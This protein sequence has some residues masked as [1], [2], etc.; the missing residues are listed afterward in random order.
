MNNSFYIELFK[1]TDKLSQDEME[2]LIDSKLFNKILITDIHP[3]FRAYTIAHEGI[4]KGSNEF[5]REIVLKYVKSIIRKIYQTLQTDIPAY[6]RHYT[7]AD[8]YTREEIGTIV[9]KTIIDNDGILETI[10]IIYIKPGWRDK[11][12]DVASL[13]GIIE[14]VDDTVVNVKE[15]EAIALSNKNIDSPGFPNAKLIQQLNYFVTEKINHIKPEEIKNMRLD[16]V[17]E[18]VKANAVQP[19]QLFDIEQIIGDKDVDARIKRELQTKHEHIRRVE[20]KLKTVEE[21]RKKEYESLNEQMK[22]YQ[23][24]IWGIRGEEHVKTKLDS[25]QE[26]DELKS[27]I[28]NKIMKKINPEISKYETEEDLCKHIDVLYTEEYDEISKLKSI[29]APNP[30][31][32]KEISNNIIE[33]PR[34]YPKPVEK[35]NEQ[36]IKDPK[37]AIEAAVNELLSI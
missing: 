16:D 10:A 24:K 32:K 30:V 1:R 25:I 21:E 7:E 19:N 28:K 2:E 11:E 18:F 29:F 5:N 34:K 3:E 22:T 15:I 6:F 26:P 9:G 36:A 12:L 4:A 33:I 35:S 14:I 27:I 13:E 23:H 8:K 20:E 17:I 31:E 37:D